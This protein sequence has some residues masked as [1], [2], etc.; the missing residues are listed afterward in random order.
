[1]PR[2]RR[3]PVDAVHELR[4][5][6]AVLGAPLVR[7]AHQLPQQLALGAARR[8]VVDEREEPWAIGAN[9]IRKPC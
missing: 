2:S 4:E 1:M 9:K 7:E 6:R 8:A 5:G 3:E